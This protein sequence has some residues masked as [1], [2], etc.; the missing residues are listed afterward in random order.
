MPLI[1]DEDELQSLIG[2]PLGEAWENP[3]LEEKLKAR[4]PRGYDLYLSTISQMNET[5]EELV[6]VLNLDVNYVETE[7]VDTSPM[8][9]KSRNR[10]KSLVIKDNIKYE[11]QRA[12]FALGK[13]VRAKLFGEIASYNARLR[14]LLDTSDEIETIRSSR[15]DLQGPGS[16]KGFTKIWYHAS[17]VFRL[18]R[19]AWGCECLPN[20][21]A[22]IM[23]QHRTNPRVNFTLSFLFSRLL[24][25][26]RCPSWKSFRSRLDLVD[27]DKSDL[28]RQVQRS[29]SEITINTP[30]RSSMRSSL[31]PSIRKDLSSSSSIIL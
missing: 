9:K 3:L 16:V 12:K 13:S 17:N 15:R 20:H 14:D 25:P 10:L 24:T 5:M 21:H 19:Q 4:L 6:N 27:S 31:R 22:N 7:S 8:T 11:G 23:L 28:S 18:L 29:F 30:K 2:D 26:P 1:A